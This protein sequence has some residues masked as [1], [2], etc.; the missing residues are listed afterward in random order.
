MP[1]L[2]YTTKVAPKRT[3][4]ELQGLLA[5][6][7]AERVSVYYDKAGEPVALE[8]V[9]RVQEEPVHFK[10]PCNV[11]G[12]QR[13]LLRSKLHYSKQTKEHARSVAWRIV[14]TWVEAQ[15]AV[16]DSN[17]A[18]LAE[19]FLPYV[20]DSNGQTMYARFIESHQKQLSA[21]GKSDE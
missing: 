2:S 20:I 8:F 9:I 6:K 15:L 10:L 3:A 5:T 21:G 11:D 14:K 19:V 17:Q 4:L 7:G 18:D 13:A 1:I 12:V 16:V